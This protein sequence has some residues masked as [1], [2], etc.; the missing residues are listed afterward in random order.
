MD[1]IVFSKQKERKGKKEEKKRSNV[2]FIQMDVTVPNLEQVLLFLVYVLRPNL[3]EGLLSFISSFSPLNSGEH[4]S[5][6]GLCGF[7]L[8]FMF[9]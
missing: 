7:F 1:T 5:S 4:Q 2:S 9:R 3:V 8:D 6:T